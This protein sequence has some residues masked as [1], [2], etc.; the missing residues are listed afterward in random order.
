MLGALRAT[1]NDENNRKREKC[2][3]KS[4][5]Y[6]VIAS[7][8]LLASCDLLFDS[9]EDQQPAFPA[10]LS[11]RGTISGVGAASVAGSRVEA[12]AADSDWVVVAVYWAPGFAPPD[13]MG[14]VGRLWDGK[15]TGDEVRFDFWESAEVIPVQPDGSFLWQPP[16]NVQ[17][18]LFAVDLND[19]VDPVRGVLS[20]GTAAGLTWDA[21]ATALLA[22]AV[23]LG[24]YTP[25]ETSLTWTGTTTAEAME[26]AGNLSNM[27]LV[28]QMSFFDDG[29]RLLKSQ[30]STGFDIS[31][32]GIVERDT[33]IIFALNVAGPGTLDGAPATVSDLT[34]DG[35]SAQAGLEYFN[36]PEDPFYVIRYIAKGAG[37]TESTANEF[38]PPRDIDY[39]VRD[40]SGEFVTR[41][42][43]ADR[44]SEGSWG[45]AYPGAGVLLGSIADIGTSPDGG[46]QTREWFFT[47]VLSE[48]WTVRIGDLERGVVFD[49]PILENNPID[50]EWYAVPVPSVKGVLNAAGD[51]ITAVELTWY[52]Y[53]GGSMQPITSSSVL[54]M[55]I[56]SLTFSISDPDETVGGLYV[57]DSI[58]S[59]MTITL[60][61]P[62][63]VALLDIIGMDWVMPGGGVIISSGWEFGA[64]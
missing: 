29:I 10:G 40:D 11:V 30:L 58:T 53:V 21:P 52:Q 34:G 42:M 47:D 54:S 48:S 7:S 16:E 8:V 39:T 61:E 9:E 46:E 26:A 59:P 15:I 35:I 43:P 49:S 63:P 1:Y 60:D 57:V 2:D 51:S 45:D 36:T 6:G 25:S 37:L 32:D 62:M 31:R 24:T 4:R 41:T 28:Q 56:P 5:I 20:I 38:R 14:D 23:D 64:Q 18:V 13:A 3:E 55:V 33:R 12:S 27:D 22:G 44:F 50:D 19:A 17:Y